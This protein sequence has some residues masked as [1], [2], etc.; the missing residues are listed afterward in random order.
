MANRITKHIPNTITCLNLFSGCVCCVMAF[1]QLYEYALLCVILSAV[2]DFFD[3][4]AA[5]A[6]DAHSIIGKDIDSLADDISFGLAPSVIMYSFLSNYLILENVLMLIAP[7]FAFLIAVFSALRLAKFNNDSRQVSSFYGLPVPANALFW[8]SA[9]VGYYDLMEL[10]PLWGLFLAI[11]I[12]CWLLVS[13]IPMFSLKFKNLTWQDNK[14]RYFFL[15]VSLALLCLG[16]GGIA[17][18]I[19]WYILLSVGIWM[20]SLF[21]TKVE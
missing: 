14:I 12:S 1:Y 21:N 10:I 7:F 9:V 20:Y 16:V 18:I 8:A 4:L 15:A 17:L 2:F 19:L 3:G 6:L 13:D 5:R 11:A